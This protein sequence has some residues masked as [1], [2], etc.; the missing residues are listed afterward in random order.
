ME[1]NQLSLEDKLRGWLET[2]GYPLEMRVAQACQ[3][4]GARVIQSEYYTDANSDQSRE[5]DV[6]ADWQS[7]DAN[8]LV[9][10]S[11]A[12]ECKSSR[13]K[14]WI[15]FVSSKGRLNPIARVAQ[16][17]ASRLGR[18][19]LSRIA[20]EASAQGL[21]I[22]ALP[23]APGYSITQAFT[24]GNDVCY[25]AA[26]AVASAAAAIASQIDGF[27][28]GLRRFDN[29]QIVFPVLVTEARLFAAALESGGSVSLKEIDSGVLLWRNP[30]VGLPHTIIHVLTFSALGKFVNG[31]RESAE[32]FLALCTSDYKKAI[33]DARASLQPKGLEDLGKR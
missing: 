6:V 33:E 32:K 21:P 7:F 1:S 12:I 14:P 20:R 29:L 3:E 2:Q 15:L 19:A 30:I 28:K 26:S 17:A 22:F 25:M 18:L 8:V 4:S 11:L 10:I 27:S 23:E 16:R 31:A 9:R 24:S 5:I 13:D